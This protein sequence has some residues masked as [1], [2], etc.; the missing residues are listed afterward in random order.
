MSLHQLSAAQAAARIAAGELTSEALVRA[1]LEH[2]ESRE[3]TVAAWSFLDPQKAI[4]E[5][6]MCDRRANAGVLHGVPVGIKDIIDTADMPTTYGSAIYRDHRPASDA[7]CVVNTR[8]AGGIILGKTVSTEFAFRYPGRTRNPHNVLHS[9]GGSSSGSAAAVADGMVPLSVGTQTAGSVIRPASYCGVYGYKPTFGL[10]SFSGV[11]HLC[12]NLDTLGCMARTLADIALYRDVLMG[13]AP[14][15]IVQLSR[16]PRIGFCRTDHWHEAQT[17]ARDALEDAAQRLRG[18]GASVIDFEL[19]PSFADCLSRYWRIA[20][21]EARN[22]IAHDLT[23]H[24][25]NVSIAARKLIEDSEAVSIDTYMSDLL[26]CESMKQDLEAAM[27][28]VDILLT[29]SALG[30]APAGLTDTGAVTFNYLWT[31]LHTPAITIPAFTG[32][33]GLPMGAQLVGKRWNDDYV[34]AA[35]DWVRSALD[36]V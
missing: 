27:S 16:A 28:D 35:T 21:F 22:C 34:L 23:H 19:P 36:V 31:L 14:S 11:R 5:A 6:R 18:A 7:V 26:V 24:R 12:E 9:P 20:N 3:P 29:L 33:M 17:P 1:C 13:G 30:E 10:L 8:R 32:P 25:E 2:I 15:G 4:A